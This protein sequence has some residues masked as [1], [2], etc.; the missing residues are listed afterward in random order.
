MMFRTRMLGGLTVLALLIGLLSVSPAALA[1]NGIEEIDFYNFT[2]DLSEGEVDTVVD[3]KYE[4]KLPEDVA[5][6]VVNKVVYGYFDNDRER[7]AAVWLTFS[8]SQSD[9]F[10]FS[11]VFVL[12]G[13]EAVMVAETERG[14]RAYGGLH[15][16]LAIDG[17]LTE[18]RFSDDQGAC[19][20]T[21]I[22]RTRYRLNGKRLTTV[23]K[24]TRRLYAIVTKT[25]TSLRFPHRLSSATLYTDG[26]SEI[27][28]SLSAKVGQRL[29]VNPVVTSGATTSTPKVV[30]LDAAS[31]KVLAMVD[32]KPLTVKLPVGKLKVVLRGEGF[33]DVSVS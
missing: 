21:E 6:L 19:C 29:T 28:F 3:G 10:S 18:D 9:R 13:S 15:D 1:T 7:D 33:V 30:V 14:D 25:F 16:L 20:P 23:G 4:R 17:Q 2:Y 26:T 31:G 24:P 32:G 12:R 11:Q 5:T 22:T 27:G 8:T